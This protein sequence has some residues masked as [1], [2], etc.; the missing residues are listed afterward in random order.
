M[1]LWLGHMH[2]H[3]VVLT[4]SLPVVLVC[5]LCALAP[6]T[7]AATDSIL[8]PAIRAVVTEKGANYLLNAAL[9]ALLFPLSGTP[10]SEVLGSTSVPVV[11]VID[12]AITNAVIGSFGYTTATVSL[13]VQQQDALQATVMGVRAHMS[14]DW[15]WKQRNWPHVNS[16]G[17]A[18][19]SISQSSFLL[20]LA[21]SATPAGTPSLTVRNVAVSF[22]QLDVTVSD[23]PF[24]WLGNLVA[25]LVKGSVRKMAEQKVSSDLKQMTEQ[26]GN[27]A[28]SALSLHVALPPLPHVELDLSLTSAPVVGGGALTVLLKGQVQNGS[29]PS[30]PPLPHTALPTDV[31][32]SS[33]LAGNVDQYTFNSFLYL[34]FSQGLMDA[35]VGQSNIPPSLHITL[36]TNLFSSMVPELTARF[37]DHPITWHLWAVQLPQ[38]S[39]SSA[40]GL[41]L[42]LRFNMDWLVGHDGDGGQSSSL[43]RLLF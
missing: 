9:P 4:L 14:M 28:L 22:S 41:L 21:L 11:G 2:G 40:R 31:P 32:A 37:P 29:N 18:Q 5:L 23:T 38:M 24:A 10:L 17:S 39:I 7:V 6:S 3:Q 8:L 27:Q 19:V 1:R 12:Y 34:L 15:S 16:T 43:V 26:M 13:G 42:D 20:A 35:F 25:T 30:D 33:M 36:N